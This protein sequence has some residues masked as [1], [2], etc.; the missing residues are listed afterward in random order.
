[1]ARNTDGAFSTGP[2]EFEPTRFDCM[3][4]NIIHKPSIAFEKLT[5]QYFSHMNAEEGQTDY[6]VERSKVNLRSSWSA[7]WNHL[8]ILDS[9]TPRG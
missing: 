5:F 3:Y 6:F 4:A 7:D 9:P 2:C 1:M 8:N